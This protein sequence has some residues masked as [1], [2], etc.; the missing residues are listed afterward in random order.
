MT[1][2]QKLRALGHQLAEAELYGFNIPQPLDAKHYYMLKK[3][4]KFKSVK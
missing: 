1:L 3:F 4:Y 2:Q